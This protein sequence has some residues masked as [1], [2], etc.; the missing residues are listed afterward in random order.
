MFST[1]EPDFVRIGKDLSMQARRWNSIMIRKKEVVPKF[2]LEYFGIVS[3]KVP[4]TFP[5]IKHIMQCFKLV[6]KVVYLTTGNSAADTILW[7]E[8]IGKLQWWI[9][10]VWKVFN[11]QKW[12]QTLSLLVSISSFSG[13]PEAK[14]HRSRSLENKKV[15]HFGNDEDDKRWF[16]DFVNALD[17]RI[18]QVYYC[19]LILLIIFSNYLSLT[20]KLAP[21]REER[22]DMT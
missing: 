17:S 9:N 14:A 13:R 1:I 15:T 16:A 3:L 5:P 10:N 20:V 8:P 12:Y 21:R 2:T 4:R 7:P 6:R 11:I 18:V 19:V 22:F